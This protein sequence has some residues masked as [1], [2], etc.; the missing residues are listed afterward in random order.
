[1]SDSLWE[2]LYMHAARRIAIVWPNTRDMER[3]APSDFEVALSVLEDVASSLV[4]PRATRD[5]PKEVAVIVEAS[6]D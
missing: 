5:Q 4:D 2:G 1:M 3:A 6:P